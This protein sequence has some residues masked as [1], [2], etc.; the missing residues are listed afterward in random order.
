MKNFKMVLVLLSLTILC[1]CSR[2]VFINYENKKTGV[3]MEKLNVEKLKKQE[4]FEND[5]ERIII[6]SFHAD[7]NF[8]KYDLFDKMNNISTVINVFTNSKTGEYLGYVKS[9]CYY[10]RYFDIPCI[11]GI[12]SHFDLE[13]NLKT[14]GKYLYTIVSEEDFKKAS[15][16]RVFVHDGLIKYKIGMYEEYGIDGEIIKTTNQEEGIVFNFKNVYE[17]MV[18]SNADIYTKR[19]YETFRINVD[20]EKK[21]WIVE[22][23]IIKSKEVVLTEINYVTGEIISEKRSISKRAF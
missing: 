3:K 5:K 13:G 21:I 16:E 2:G 20:H 22:F 17:F 11:I 8:T 4:N 19:S 10:E 7:K 15:L 6:S 14:K 23:Y 1:G 18:N 12:V 9:V